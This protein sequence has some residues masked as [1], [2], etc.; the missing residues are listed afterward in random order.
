[1]PVGLSFGKSNG[2]DTR[3]HGSGNIG[4]S[5][6]GRVLGRRYFWVV[7]AL[8]FLTSLLP[9][10]IASAI[11][12]MQIAPTARRQRTYLLRISVGVG[13]ILGYV[14]PMYLKFRGGN[15]VAASTGVILPQ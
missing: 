14:L 12:Q 1:M 4:A 9:M 3:Q 2:T 11:V 7:F 5:N 13:A 10:A 6:A 15:S 8:D